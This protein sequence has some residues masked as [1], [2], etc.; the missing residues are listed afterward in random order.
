[1]TGGA[2]NEQKGPTMDRPQVWTLNRKSS[3]RRGVL[4][5][6]AKV[7]AAEPKLPLTRY[8]YQPHHTPLSCAARTEHK[9]SK[10]KDQNGMRGGRLGGKV[11]SCHYS[12]FPGFPLDRW[13]VAAVLVVGN[14]DQ[15]TLHWMLLRSE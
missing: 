2:S 10:G 6:E 1:M 14:Q 8:H 7:E 15:G 4:C 9:A 11:A 5:Y 13:S 12:G 3:T